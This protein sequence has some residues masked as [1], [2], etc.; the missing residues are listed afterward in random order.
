MAP[1]ERE[2]LAATIAAAYAEIASAPPELLLERCG[3]AVEAVLAGLEQGTLRVAEPTPEGWRVNAW[4]RQAILLHFRMRPPRPMP[5]LGGPAFDKLELRFAGHG[6]AE[7]RALG[8]RIV[9]GAIVRRGA[10]IGR[11]AVLMPCFVNVGAHVGEGTM[12]DTWATV[13]SCAQVGRRCH[14]SGGAGIGGVLEPPQ[15]SPTIIEDDCF[16]GARSEIV[17]GV[18]VEQGSVIAMG[19]FIGQSTPIY[20]RERG[21]ILKGRVPAGSVVVPGAL[22]SRDGRYALAAAVIVKRVDAATR[23]KV[24]LNAL[25]REAAA[26]CQ[27]SEIER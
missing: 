12:I 18:V 20:D 2:R 9:P 27:T 13:G 14:V 3:A 19:C 7:F 4:V 16:I 5:G 26:L 1:G 21:E 25:L 11:D 17:E 24:G 10:F 6:E 22:P 15:A 8:A 23:A